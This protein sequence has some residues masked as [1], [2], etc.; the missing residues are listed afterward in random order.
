MWVNVYDT[1][2][3]LFYKSMAYAKLN[4]GDREQTIVFNPQSGCFE[5]VD[6][7]DKN[8]YKPCLLYEYMGGDLN[9]WTACEASALAELKQWAE[10]QGVR[11]M[12]DSCTGYPEVVGDREF[13]RKILRNKKVPLE[14]TTV[15]PKE[16]F[17]AWHEIRTQED[18]NEFMTLFAGFHDAALK[19]L[20]YK[21]DYRGRT[22]VNAI[23]D[24]SC[25]FGVAELCFE[26]LLDLHL[27][28]FGEY[29][30]NEIDDGTLLVAATGV[31]W[32]DGN[33]EAEDLSYEGDYIKARKLKWRKIGYRSE[34]ARESRILP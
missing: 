25:W 8:Y 7:M 2:K 6:R 30:L 11:K 18:A 21:E 33:L 14:E 24:N 26:G 5:L 32:A 15:K 20:T 10:E 34:R 16:N 19:K 28:A 3:G 22:R 29:C 27:A 1:E 9:G 17:S 31:F 23:F 12:P 4:E 13:M